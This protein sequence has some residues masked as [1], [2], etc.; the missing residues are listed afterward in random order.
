M[1]FASWLMQ[2]FDPAETWWISAALFHFLWQATLIAAL[3]AIASRVAGTTA[4]MRYGLHLAGLLAMALCI[5]LNLIMIPAQFANTDV[6]TQTRQDKTLDTLTAANGL[7]TEGVADGVG[8][9]AFS[10]LPDTP[11]ISLTAV[12]D[13]I[14]R[15][16][17]ETSVI[18]STVSVPTLGQ[19]NLASWTVLLW[20][21]GVALMTLRLSIALLGGWRLQRAAKRVTESALS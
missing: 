10:E 2:F 17:P 1:I 16:T 9:A 11:Q 12:D 15:S 19:Q 6:S 3:T 5:P 20:L 14:A 13:L 18:Q 21:S 8:L 7:G 4:R